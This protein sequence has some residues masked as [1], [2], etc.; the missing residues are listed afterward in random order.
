MIP[1][2]SSDLP[3]LCAR[4]R[5]Q[6]GEVERLLSE[7]DA[8]HASWRPV[9]AKWSLTGHTAHMS[10][11]NG[12]YVESIR[13]ALDDASLPGAGMTEEPWRHPAIATW[14]VGMNQPPPKLWIKTFKSMVP[15]PGTTWEAALAEFVLVQDRLLD[16]I[17]RADGLDLGRIRFGSPFL[18]LLRLSAGTA[19]ALIVAHNNRHIWLMHEVNRM[20]SEG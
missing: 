6:T 1:Y 18:G 13:V 14:F 2:S 19:I 16:A 15:D 20:R 11:V 8:E 5:D 3:G 12:L 9:E 17:T 4:I 10:I 7:G